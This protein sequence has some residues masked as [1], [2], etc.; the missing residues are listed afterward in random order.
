MNNVVIQ[1]K[2]GSIEESSSC[3]QWPFAGSLKKDENLYGETVIEYIGALESGRSEPS[4]ISSDHFWS[5]FQ[6]LMAY[7]SENRHNFLT[8]TIQLRLW[9]FFGIDITDSNFDGLDLLVDNQGADF[10]LVCIRP[11][12]MSNKLFEISSRFA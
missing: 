2:A 4:G 1:S 3:T 5:M 9:C 12:T 11:R 6:L 7:F 8:L 10:H